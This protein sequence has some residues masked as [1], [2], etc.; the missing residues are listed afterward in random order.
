MQIESPI[1]FCPPYKGLTYSSSYI[2]HTL[3]IYEKEVDEDRLHDRHHDGHHDHHHD[4]HQDCDDD[5]DHPWGGVHFLNSEMQRPVRKEEAIYPLH[6]NCTSTLL[7]CT[8]LYHTKIHC[9]ASLPLALYCTLHCTGI[10]CP[11][12]LLY[13]A[14]I[15]TVLHLNCNRTS[16]HVLYCTLLKSTARLQLYFTSCN[17][18]YCTLNCTAF[19]LP[20]Y[21]VL[22]CKYT[23]HLN[24]LGSNCTSPLFPTAIVLH[25]CNTIEL[26]FNTALQSHCA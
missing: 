4:G 12:I 22:H 3:H 19:I 14:L 1:K 16:P 18:L 20:L 13:L 2:M 11:A 10:H 25:L 7:D 8:V 21:A 17:A 5:D 23:L 24:A 6:S 26:H 15:Y 9:P